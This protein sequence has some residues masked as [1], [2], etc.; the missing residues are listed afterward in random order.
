MKSFFKLVEIQTKVASVLPFLYG[1]V[2][3]QWMFNAFNGLRTLVFLGALLC[4]DMATTAL[5]NYMDYKRDKLK[6]GY[7]FEEHNAIVSDQIPIKRVKGI[8]ATLLVMGIVLGLLL[9]GLT[10]YWI[11]LIG[12]VSFGVGILYSYGPLPI[13]H[14]PLGEIFSGVMMGF[15]IFF[16]TVYIQFE[17]PQLLIADLAGG[18]L[19]L[20]VDLLVIFQLILWSVPF[21]LGISGIMLGNNIAD[22]ADDAINQRKTLPQV[23]G[24]KN[25]LLVLYG[26]YGVSLIQL[27]VL[28]VFQV[29]PLYGAFLALVFIPIAKK[30]KAFSANPSKAVTFKRVVE[31]YM[32]LALGHIVVLLIAIALS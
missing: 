5:N 18:V 12:V 1:V 22:Y 31:S 27:V 20:Q 9:V 19:S 28:L 4:I 29:L 30:L 7:N 2:F 23:I 17:S 25:S 8:L 15:F 16:V 21:V 14:T 3:S 32:I 6:Q 24:V 13:S 26:F 11:L 10:D